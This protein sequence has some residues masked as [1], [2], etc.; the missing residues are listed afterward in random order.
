MSNP[1]NADSGAP[2]VVTTP[3]CPGQKAHKVEIVV[4]TS[5]VVQVV[6]ELT[7][8][9]SSAAEPNGPSEASHSASNC[10]T[11]ADAGASLAQSLFGPP[12]LLLYQ[13]TQQK[14]LP[15][16]SSDVHETAC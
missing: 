2:A 16:Y 5:L 12:H 15:I 11:A 13:V 7:W 9:S 3:T 14:Q 4:I 6:A 1:L 8:K 10:Q